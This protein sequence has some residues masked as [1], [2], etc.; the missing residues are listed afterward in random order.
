M[1]V[2]L[3]TPKPPEMTIFT[4]CGGLVAVAVAV[5]AVSSVMAGPA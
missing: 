2:V 4:G 1:A 3:P 5:G